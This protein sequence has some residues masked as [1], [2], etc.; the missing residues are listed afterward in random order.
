MKRYP[1]FLVFLLGISLFIVNAGYG[2]DSEIISFAD[3][4]LEQVVRNVL[5]MPP[6]QAITKEKL[7][8]LTELKA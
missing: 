2:K 4:N 1:V 7:L 3:P 6:E 5:E 8:K